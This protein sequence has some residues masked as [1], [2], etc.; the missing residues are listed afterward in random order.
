MRE[1]VFGLL[2]RRGQ[3]NVGFCTWVKMLLLE[4]YMG[5]QLIEMLANTSSFSKGAPNDLAFNLPT[6]GWKAELEDFI[7]ATF[8]NKSLKSHIE[9]LLRYKFLGH[10]GVL[11]LAKLPAKENIDR[12]E[13]YEL[14]PERLY[15]LTE[16]KL[17]YNTIWVSLNVVV[18]LVVY[19]LTKD[20]TMA[21]L[22]G[23][24]VEFIRR[25]KW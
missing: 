14:N 15:L 2:L 22:S 11:R 16:L 4:A 25:F 7:P 24:I 17:S 18:D 9:Q 6:N 1:S 20:I 5:E 3:S 13:L 21:L 23:G 10:Y 8:I 19:L 12:K